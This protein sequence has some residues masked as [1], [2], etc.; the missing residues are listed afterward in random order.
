MAD[1]PEDKNNPA[2]PKKR[3]DARKKGDVAMSK[4]VTTWLI[5][6]GGFVSLAA[7]APGIGRSAFTYTQ[8]T[9]GS[10]DSPM[11]QGIAADF[12]DTYAMM[13]LPI[14]CIGVALGMIAT[15]GQT[16]GLFTMEKIIKPDLSKFN[17]FMKIKEMFLSVQSLIELGMSMLKVIIVAIVAGWTLWEFI[18]LFF[19]S[20]PYNLGAMV[21][22]TLWFTLKLAGRLAAATLVLAIVDYFIKDYQYEKKLKMSDKEVK[23]EHKNTEGDGEIK[24]KRKAMARELLQQISVEGVKG[25]DVVVVNPT[26]FSVALKYDRDSM[27]AP[28]VVAKGVDAR[29]MR[30]RE[31]AREHGVPIV[32]KPPL[33]R[34]L[35]RQVKVGRNVPG[36]LF[37]AVAEV[38]AYVYRLKN[39][40]RRKAS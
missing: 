18:L 35:F 24:G 21:T 28:Q 32:S 15:F 2:T 36:E 37:K 26:H 9:L 29:A 3:A 31:L 10:L 39:K 23:D 40:S 27:V 7:L 17:I 30:I 5:L 14:L 22:E 12:M 19:S 38:L 34:A 13:S 33:A 1:S 8:R 11:D 6:W 20:E 4:D 25:A 16:K